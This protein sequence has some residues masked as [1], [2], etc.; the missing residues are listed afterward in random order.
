M[1]DAE[2]HSAQRSATFCSQSLQT[3]KLHVAFGLAQEQCVESFMEWVSMAEQLHPSHTSP[4]EKQ[5][6]GCS[7]VKD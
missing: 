7:G 4:S 3:S 6:I 2:A 1:T 5:T